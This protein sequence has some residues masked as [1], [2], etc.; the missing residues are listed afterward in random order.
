MT[1]T[2]PDWLPAPP[3]PRSH[4]DEEP[5]SLEEIV[6]VIRRTKAKSS[7]SP[8]DWVS[9]Q[10]LKHCPSLVTALLDLYNSCWSSGVMP[11][12]WK[13]GVIRLIPKSSAADNPNDPGNF[14]PIALT[15]CVGK[16]FTT[17]LKNRWL[18]YMID[19]GYMDTAIQKAFINGVPGCT[20]HQWELAT[21]SSKRPERSIAPSQCAG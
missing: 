3:P 8:N 14:R 5:I 2:R 9:Y 19:N 20:E 11:A 6:G 18:T 7:P 21:Q 13:Q 15:S 10:V 4:F 12:A 17:V 16:V 1:Y